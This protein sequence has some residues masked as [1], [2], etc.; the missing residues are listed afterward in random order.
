MSGTPPTA[1]EL[2]ERIAARVVELLR[3]DAPLLDATAVALRLGRSRDWVYRHAAELGAVRL[4]E[5]DRPRLGFDPAK[6][7]AY[8]ASVSSAG[9]RTL[10]G[11]NGPVKP[12]T[13]RRRVSA[14]ASGTSFCP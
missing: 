1:D 13:R 10:D 14:N 9:R 3:G 11:G 8:G 4:G 12:T 6:V 5:G 2:V 7:A